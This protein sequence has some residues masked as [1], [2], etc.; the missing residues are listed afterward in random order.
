MSVAVRIVPHKIPLTDGKTWYK[1][2][3]QRTI[4]RIGP[5][6]MWI[7]WTVG[8]YQS[9]GYAISCRDDVRICYRMNQDESEEK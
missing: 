5:F 9:L 1:V 2:Q 6:R 8:D 4:F 7:W 3:V